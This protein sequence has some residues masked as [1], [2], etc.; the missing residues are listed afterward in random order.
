[1]PAM[2]LEE[3]VT[4]PGLDGSE[5]MG[6]TDGNTINLLDEPAVVM[7]KVKSIPTQADTQGEMTSG[8]KAL[9]DL[10]R[11]C[12][13]PEVYREYHERFI[14][15]EGKFFGKLKEILAEKI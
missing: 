11:V 9:Y 4:V 13:P 2:N 5:K 10:V 3:P 14:Q 1:V 12:C 15:G 8:T 7:K 6:K